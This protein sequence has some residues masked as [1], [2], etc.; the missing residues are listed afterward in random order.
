MGP[1]F[2]KLPVAEFAEQAHGAGLRDAR[3]DQEKVELSLIVGMSAHEGDGPRL[4]LRDPVYEKAEWAWM[5][6]VTASGVVSV[7]WTA[8][9]RFFSYSR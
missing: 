2:L 8:L 5:S 1:C 9:R 4:E 3:D 6:S 7:L